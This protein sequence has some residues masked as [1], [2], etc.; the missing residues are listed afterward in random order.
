[1]V[2][3]WKCVGLGNKGCP[4]NY[5]ENTYISILGEEVVEGNK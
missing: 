3:H 5:G 2:K 4:L 1:M